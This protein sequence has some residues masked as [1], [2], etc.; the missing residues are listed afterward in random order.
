LSSVLIAILFF[1]SNA[2]AD[3]LY[4]KIRGTVTDPSG[5]VVPG[6]KVTVTNTATGISRSMTSFASGGF[7]FANLL[8]PGVY[9]VGVEK[10]GFRK[11]ESTNIHLDVNQVYVVTAPLEVGSLNQ[12][13]TVEATP[14]QVEKTSMEL[15]VTISGNQIVDMPLNGRN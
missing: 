2:R 10:E 11:F 13:V 9:D 12:I 6:A 5:L 7:E 3:E 14:T 4:G 15:G 8:A 1:G